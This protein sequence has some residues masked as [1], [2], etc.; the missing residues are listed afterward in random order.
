MFDWIL[1]WLLFVGELYCYLRNNKWLVVINK[2]WQISRKL[3]QGPKFRKLQE[4][5]WINV[6]NEIFKFP[7]RLGLFFQINYLFELFLSY[8]S[9]PIQKLYIWVSFQT[10]RKRFCKLQEAI[11]L[12][13]INKIFKISP[14]FDLFCR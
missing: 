10:S 3:R 4:P 9:Y 13:V 11:W 12:T 1:L 8:L 2:I 5:I 7:H 6:I 14:H